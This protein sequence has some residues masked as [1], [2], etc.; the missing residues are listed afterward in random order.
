MS[1]DKK[2]ARFYVISHETITP[3][4]EEV[5]YERYF[6]TL[7]TAMTALKEIIIE[8]TR[9]YCKCC[10]DDGEWKIYECKIYECKKDAKKVVFCYDTMKLFKGSGSSNDEIYKS[11][12]DK[13]IRDKIIQNKGKH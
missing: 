1:Y 9:N 4:K 6:D 13:S 12:H 2:T 8:E 11:V 7:N 3:S 10:D 5:F